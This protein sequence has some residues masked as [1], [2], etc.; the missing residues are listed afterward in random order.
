MLLVLWFPAQKSGHSMNRHIFPKSW[1]KYKVQGKYTSV[2][3]FA[4][5]A[6][7]LNDELRIVMKCYNNGDRVCRIREMHAHILHMWKWCVTCSARF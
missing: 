7:S 1:E 4:V 6:F 5:L 3:N 2:T